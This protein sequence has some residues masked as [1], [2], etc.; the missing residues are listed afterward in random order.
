MSLIIE[1]QKYADASA[2]RHQG[3]AQVIMKKAIDD[4]IAS[5]MIS[6]AYKTG[7]ILPEIVLGN[8]IGAQVRVQDILKEHKV[9]IAF[10]RGNWCPYCNI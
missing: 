10:Y 7:D 5:Y 8:A 3:E 4:L 1:L 9:I 2:Q 6:K